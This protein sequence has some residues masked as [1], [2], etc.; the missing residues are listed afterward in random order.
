VEPV[1]RERWIYRGRRR[2]RCCS[3]WA[4]GAG[5]PRRAARWDA[6]GGGLLRWWTTGGGRLTTTPEGGGQNGTEVKGGID[7]R[8]AEEITGFVRLNSL[9][10]GQLPGTFGSARR[11]PFLLPRRSCCCGSVSVTANTGQ[12][13][14][15]NV[16]LFFLA[17]SCDLFS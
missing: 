3:G 5:P 9:G 6:C 8:Q 17:I 12:R 15:E 7:R 11:F 10:G 13:N 14:A 1:G 2:R 4:V 16:S